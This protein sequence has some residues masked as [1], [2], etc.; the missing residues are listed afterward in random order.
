M[1]NLTLQSLDTLF[2]M[3]STEAG[4]EIMISLNQLRE[5]NGHPFK[6]QDDDEMDM[7]VQSIEQNGVLNPIIVRENI[8]ENGTYEILSGHRRKHACERAGMEEIPAIVKNMSDED[9]IILMVDSN[10]YREHILPSEKAFAYRMKQDAGKRRGKRTDLADSGAQNTAAEL[11]STH[12]ESARTVFRYIRLTYLIP[13]LLELVDVGQLTLM[14]GVTLSYLQNEHQT[15]VWEYYSQKKK[16]PNTEQAELLKT[17]SSSPE[18][19]MEDITNM[20]ISMFEETSD[21]A[22]I[23]PQKV[24]FKQS[25]LNELF[26]EDASED[27]IKDIIIRLLQKWHDGNIDI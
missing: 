10:M 21:K 20:L 7:L 8:H 17:L 11:G 1:S 22:P 12:S 4:G 18:C 6:V 27:Y 16:L 5:F 15:K 13:E 2:G 24:I 25:E 14:T 26:E 9:A 23:K 3:D 19:S